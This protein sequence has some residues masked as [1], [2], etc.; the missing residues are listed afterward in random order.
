MSERNLK[1]RDMDLMDLLESDLSCAVCHEIFINPLIINCSHSFCKFCLYQ[2]L[3]SRKSDCPQCRVR[4]TSQAE[5]LVLRNII[6]KLVQ[7]ASPQIQQSRSATVNQRLKEIEDVT[8]SVDMDD[9][10]IKLI[11]RRRF[12]NT[13]EVDD[14]D[15]E[16]D[17]D[18]NISSQAD[19]E[20][21][22]DTSSFH[23]DILRV[24][25]AQDNHQD[26]EEMN[27]DQPSL[28]EVFESSEND[29]DDSSYI[30]D[31]DEEQPDVTLDSIDCYSP[32]SS[33]DSDVIE[34]EF[35][36]SSS[37]SSN[38]SSSSSG[39]VTSVDE[40][41]DSDDEEEDDSDSPIEIEEDDE[42]ED[43]EEEEEDEGE[44]EEEDEDEDSDGVSFPYNRTL[45]R[46][47]PMTDEAIQLGSYYRA[48][49]DRRHIR[50]AFSPVRFDRHVLDTS[51]SDDSTDEYDSEHVMEPERYSSDST[52]EYGTSDDSN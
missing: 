17:G 5:N 28:L 44:E 46:D 51:S 39:S 4:V 6:T 34:E 47:I 22:D 19:D 21:F 43:G 27:D 15:H 48:R 41:Q 49:F 10:L 12:F 32:P 24:F 31:T 45:A 11:R 26:D 40:D 16:D 14:I 25:R 38:S 50:R 9:E 3:A 35:D 29:D 8:K 36:N 33:S 1:K 20:E 37:S 30:I 7:N 52:V 13:D 2:W 42:D 18:E 23:F